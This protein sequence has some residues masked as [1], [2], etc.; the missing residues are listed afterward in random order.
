MRK[1][2]FKDVLHYKNVCVDEVLSGISFQ[3]KDDKDKIL[4]HTFTFA[5][6]HCII[7]LAVRD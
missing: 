6:C 4:T 5:T 1:K 7:S 2:M 3:L